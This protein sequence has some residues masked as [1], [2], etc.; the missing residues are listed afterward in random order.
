M[1]S[2][3]TIRVRVL[4]PNSRAVEVSVPEGSTVGD[5]LR[6]GGISLA[7]ASSIRI[8]GQSVNLDNVVTDGQVL[9]IAADVVGA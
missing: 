4:P 7:K 5:V 6:Q 2:E 3:R 8:G 1:A 9:A